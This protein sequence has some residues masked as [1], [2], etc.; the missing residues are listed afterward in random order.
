MHRSFI[1][2]IVT[3][4]LSSAS[5]LGLAAPLAPAAA[6]TAT[7]KFDIPATDL[8]TAL[9]TFGRQ[10]GR[11]I[12]F[13]RSQ[14]AGKR[15]ARVTG[16]H[17]PRRALS[18][19]LR[20]TG[21][22]MSMANE[23]T[24]VVSVP[25]GNGDGDGEGGEM[26]SSYGEDA[27]PEAH[28]GI[29]EIL[30][31]GS[32]SQNVDIRRSEDDAQP[33]VVFGAEEIRT[34]GV[35][36]IEEFLAT[37]LPMNAQS[38]RADQ[39]A[40]IIPLGGGINLRGLGTNQ[41]VILI[42]GRRAPNP[43]AGGVSFLQS[44]IAGISPSLIERIEVLPA[45]ASGIYGGNA[46]G[47]VIN[48]ITKQD[49]SGIE[50]ETKYRNSQ[51]FVA[52]G[53]SLSA[54]GGLGIGPRTHLTA[55]VSYMQT[56]PFYFNDRNSIGRRSRER[57]LSN[58]AA[59][60]TSPL[61][62][63]ATPN[64]CA[65]ATTFSTTC[66]PIELVLDNSALV[67]STLGHVREGYRGPYPGPDGA[68]DAGNA[69]LASN[70]YNLDFGRV[71]IGRAERTN[72]VGL[73]LKH[74]LHALEFFADVYTS[75]ARSNSSTRNSV[76]VNI[77]ATSEF[78]P[79][80]QNIVVSLIG[81]ELYN[82][83]SERTR[84]ARGGVTVRLPSGWRALL[85]AGWQEQRSRNSALDAFVISPEGVNYLR[86]I[87]LRD[88]S[89]YPAVD[90][91]SFYTPV[92]T[93]RT[94][95][96]RT[97]ELSAR[98]GGPILSLPGG[99]VTLNSLLEIRRQRVSDVFA[100][101]KTLPTND[102][103]VNW[104]PPVTQRI[105][106]G[107]AEIGIPIFS[108]KNAIA[109]VRGLS[110]TAAVRRDDYHIAAG[111][112]LALPL[113]SRE[114]PFPSFETTKSSP[115]ST[116]YTLSVRYEPVRDLALRASYSTGYLVPAISQILPGFQSSL[117]DFFISL[118][119]LR[120]PQRGNT[121]LVGPVDWVTGGNPELKPEKSRSFSAGFILSPTFLAGLRLSADYVEI[122]KKDEIGVINFLDLF[123]NESLFPGRITRDPLTSADAALGYTAGRV[124]KIDTSLINLQSSTVRTID[125]Q[126]D[127]RRA[128]RRLGTFH[129]YAIATH[130]WDRRSQLTLASRVLDTVGFTDGPLEW[131]ANIGLNWRR[132]GWSAG[133][134]AQF[135]DSYSLCGA[136]ASKTS[137][138]LTTLNNGRS[139]VPS[140]TYH[141]VF[142]SYAFPDKALNGV[143]AGL[144]IALGVQNIPNARP[145]AIAS[146]GF[147]YSTYGDLR[148]RRFEIGLRKRFD[149]R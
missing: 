140:Q 40:N 113:A 106:S 7:P 58:N 59:A 50:I 88:L 121:L 118:L 26:A 148:L 79:F 15:S 132:D 14:V 99:A 62:F 131:R 146:T 45:T 103:A 117:S 4:A 96:V 108:E 72:S 126:L 137:C 12:I 65:T 10:S 18:L 116:D 33:Y 149:V 48:I 80:Q 51:D 55:N 1:R 122:R 68:G 97:W 128:V 49:F 16:T 100:D 22:V 41:T 86:S 21:L 138:D 109:L 23:G 30:V 110:V 53:S 93:A 54:N 115:A 94:S 3:C 38:I 135:Y 104:K 35:N 124:T 20:R 43:T 61:P 8:A 46:T 127:Y 81:P 69:L 36:N 89:R 145:P 144:E 42:N 125:F 32:R 39:S 114:G 17:D 142:L 95:S 147:G 105:T 111:E 56:R 107:Y 134:N 60:I 78:N 87:A 90:L 77:P 102:L 82:T 85:E 64:F 84:M 9:E 120:D 31:V 119:D 74:N 76:L 71:Q 63:G 52:G 75:E 37:R 44:N 47:G 139:S 5:V 129:L 123:P 70:T 130:Q 25:E 143:G 136:S 91:L 92:E 34:S 133:W 11:E 141:D 66:A 19:L 101:A 29:S 83:S 28:E 13:D 27:V 98:L 2:G 112:G 6:Q 24:F 67:G 73:G 57:L